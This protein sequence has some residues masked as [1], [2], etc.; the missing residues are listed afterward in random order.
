MCALHWVFFCILHTHFCADCLYVCAFVHL[1]KGARRGGLFFVPAAFSGTGAY[2]FP[3]CLSVCVS[4]TAPPRGA[5]ENA[6]P[7]VC[8]SGDRPQG[9]RPRPADA[10]PKKMRQMTL[11]FAKRP[12]QAEAAA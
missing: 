2:L 12:K 9:K 4:V 7:R 11:C 6:L 1:C 5:D 8:P 10:P 3:D